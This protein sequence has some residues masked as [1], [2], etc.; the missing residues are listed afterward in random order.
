MRGESFNRCGWVQHSYCRTSVPKGTAWLYCKGIP[1]LLEV[2][3]ACRHTSNAHHVAADVPVGS[4][5]AALVPVLSTGLISAVEMCSFPAHNTDTTVADLAD[6]MVAERQRVGLLPLTD[7]G[8]AAESSGERPTSSPR[9][10]L[11]L[12]GGI[13]DVVVE[14]VCSP[15]CQKPKQ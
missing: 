12:P 7:G 13:L 4:V 6:T 15:G 10:R 8:E 9:L 1:T 3:Q 5:V 14:D 2:T 11:R